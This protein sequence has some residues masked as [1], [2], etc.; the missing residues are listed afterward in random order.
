MSK[1][2]MA[3]KANTKRMA[4][5]DSDEDSKPKVSPVVQQPPI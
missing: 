1:P 4:F 2:I 3:K 5:E